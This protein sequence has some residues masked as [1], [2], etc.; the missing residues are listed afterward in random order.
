MKKAVLRGKQS[1]RG[2]REAL[3]WREILPRFKR[4]YALGDDQMAEA[5]DRQQKDR[6]N[7]TVRIKESGERLGGVQSLDVCQCSRDGN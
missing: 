2:K 1:E 3:K 4:M 7:I 6:S 5:K